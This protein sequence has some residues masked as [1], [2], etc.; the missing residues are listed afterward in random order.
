MQFSVKTL[1]S[2]PSTVLKKQ[3]YKACGRVDLDSWDLCFSS[4]PNL[5]Y[6]LNWF[7]FGVHGH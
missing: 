2:I 5:L 6:V 4:A 1:G 3:N 7:T